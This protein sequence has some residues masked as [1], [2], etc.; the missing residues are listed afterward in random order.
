MPSA[1][2][3][4]QRGTD[5]RKAFPIGSSLKVLVIGIEEGGRRI[6]LSHQQALHH[7]EQAETQSYLKDSTQKSGFGLTIGEALK[8]ARKTGD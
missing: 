6:R 7:E 5:H 1:E 2:L 4:T 8:R 3:G